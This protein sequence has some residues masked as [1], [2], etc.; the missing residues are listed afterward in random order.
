MAAYMLLR[1]YIERVQQAAFF[2]KS[3]SL[4]RE[5]SN[6]CLYIVQF[7]VFL[8]ESSRQFSRQRVPFFPYK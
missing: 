7:T 3:D 8:S 2:N 5:P 6:G 4:L 1:W